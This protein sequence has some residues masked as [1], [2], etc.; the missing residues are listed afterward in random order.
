MA[1][2]DPAWRGGRPAEQ[3]R[4]E[5]SRRLLRT[6]LCLDIFQQYG[7]RRLPDRTAL[8]NLDPERG[9][10]AAAGAGDPGDDGGALADAAVRAD[11]AE[12]RRQGL[13]QPCNVT[14]CVGIR[15]QPPAEEVVQL[16]RLPDG[17]VGEIGERIHQEAA[18]LRLYFMML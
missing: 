18:R 4:G 9:A 15:T 13:L 16:H 1:P 3:G 17:E 6:I 7:L 8:R 10:A 14:G 11:E 2:N 5:P 12:L